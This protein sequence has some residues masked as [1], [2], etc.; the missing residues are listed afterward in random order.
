M[1]NR[2]FLI[3][4]EKEIME[5]HFRVLNIILCGNHN[6]VVAEWLRRLTRNQILS[7]SVGSNPTGCEIF[8]P[9]INISLFVKISGPY[10]HIFNRIIVLFIYEFLAENLRISPVFY[11]TK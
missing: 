11:I 10:L 1:A 2:Y 8:F 4:F 7:E 3:K 9:L 6:A 5:L